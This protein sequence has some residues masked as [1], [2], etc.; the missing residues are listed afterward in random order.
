MADTEEREWSCRPDPKY[1]IFNLGAIIAGIAF[2]LITGLYVNTG[3]I[4][5]ILF[6]DW[7][8]CRILIS[9]ACNRQHYLYLVYVYLICKYFIKQ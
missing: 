1:V 5:G 2:I 4:I 8:W 7:M 9:M 6:V 3:G